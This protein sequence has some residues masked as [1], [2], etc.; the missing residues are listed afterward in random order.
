[1]AGFLAPKARRHLRG[2]FSALDRD[3]DGELNVN[4]RQVVE[5][6]LGSERGDTSLI[7][8]GAAGLESYLSRWDG[9]IASN[10]E[11]VADTLLATVIASW[12][13][14]PTRPRSYLE[15]KPTLGELVSN[16]PP[17]VRIPEGDDVDLT[18]LKALISAS[19]DAL[20]LLLAHCV[21]VRIPTPEPSI[22][23]APIEADPDDAPQVEEIVC[24]EEQ[25]PPAVLQE[26]P[27]V[28]TPR[29][30]TPIDVPQEKIEEVVIEKKVP[31]IPSM[32]ELQEE[33][34]NDAKRRLR[35]RR[36]HLDAASVSTVSSIQNTPRGTYGHLQETPAEA[37]YTYAVQPNTV[38][39]LH[40]GSNDDYPQRSGLYH[41]DSVQGIQMERQHSVKMQYT[42][43]LAERVDQMRTMRETLQCLSLS[44]QGRRKAKAVKVKDKPRP[45]SNAPPN[46]G[47]VAYSEGTLMM[48][49]P[50]EVQ[51]V[52]LMRGD[53]NK[54]Q[55]RVAN[56]SKQ[57]SKWEWRCD[58]PDTE[59]ARTV[60]HLATVSPHLTQYSTAR[61]EAKPR[62]VL[63]PSHKRYISPFSPPCLV[64]DPVEAYTIR[65][66]NKSAKPPRKSTYHT[67]ERTS[68]ASEGGA[69]S[70]GGGGGGGAVSRHLDFLLHEAAVR[71]RQQ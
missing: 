54:G 62:R 59:V 8:K 25:A 1:M 30:P 70:R 19:A 35:S 46:Q 5:D 50:V 23:E 32:R 3:G 38:H 31:S 71:S 21:E 10:A 34:E 63:S 68:L 33:L 20:K 69:S 55:E 11:R 16:P 4:E 44:P 65:A 28:A 2:L 40:R 43:P 13:D 26:E 67:P 52:E 66:V 7:V 45:K 60:T 42:H 39:H 12:G 58:S 24:N 41:A 48:L 61:H 14:P 51:V 47:S 36:D 64:A 27:V 57:E 15:A 49:S 56:Q 9:G 37:S 29:S 6:V 53:E 18:F 22:P 17:G